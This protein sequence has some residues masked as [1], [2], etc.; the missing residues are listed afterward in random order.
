MK[1]TTSDKIV[2]YHNKISYITDVEQITCETE[3]L[4]PVKNE[5]LFRDTSNKQTIA[6]YI[7]GLSPIQLE[8]VK[9]V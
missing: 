9:L 7:S 3:Y 4:F 6:I 2:E 5:T 8:T 1:S